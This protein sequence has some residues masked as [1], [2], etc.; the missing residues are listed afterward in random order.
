VAKIPKGILMERW[1]GPPGKPAKKPYWRSHAGEAKS[2]FRSL[3]QALDFVEMCVGVGAQR[4][5]DMLSSQKISNL[6]LYH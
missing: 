4:V 5:R 3:Y 6:V 1:L 2:T